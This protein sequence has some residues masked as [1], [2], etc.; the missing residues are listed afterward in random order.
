MFCADDAKIWYDKIS[1]KSDL[2]KAM[3]PKKCF[4]LCYTARKSQKNPETEIKGF[5]DEFQVRRVIKGAV[6][7]S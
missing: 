7:E 6:F 2:K 4:I 1:P 3:L 5:L